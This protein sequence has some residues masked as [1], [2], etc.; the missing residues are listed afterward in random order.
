VGLF[1]HAAQELGLPFLPPSKARNASFAQGA[2]FAI[3]GATALDTDFF[4]KRG[5]G[6]TVW[7]SG[8]L[9]TQIQWLRDL[10]PSLC[11]SA[12]GTK[13]T[14]SFTFVKANSFPFSGYFLCLNLILLSFLFAPF[15]SFLRM[16]GVLRQVLVHRG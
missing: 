2:N 11:N 7:N 9:F 4:Q 13:A 15:A 3:T 12:Q 1:S 8:S 16:Q 14:G 6:K 10:K 5:L